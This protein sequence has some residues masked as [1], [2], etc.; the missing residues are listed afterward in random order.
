MVRHG[1]VHEA[2]PL[3]AEHH[4]HEQEAADRGRHHDEIRRHDLSRMI[5]QEGAP[6]L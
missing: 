3:V 6:R 2:T 4:Q 1:H 5:R